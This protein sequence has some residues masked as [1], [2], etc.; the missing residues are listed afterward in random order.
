ML[1]RILV[2]RLTTEMIERC[3]EI[4]SLRRNRQAFI[5]GLAEGGRKRRLEVFIFLA[6]F[7]LTQA[8]RA[9][10]ALENRRRFVEALK[11]AVA[12][13]LQHVRE[14]LFLVRCFWVRRGA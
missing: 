4:R 2:G 10:R 1:R 5:K 6:D 14:S 8:L 13:Q 9:L 12:E 3:E 7:V 11:Q